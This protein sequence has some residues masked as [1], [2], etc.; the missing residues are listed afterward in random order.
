MADRLFLAATHSGLYRLRLDDHFAL[1]ACHKLLAGHHYAL[2]V[3]PSEKKIYSKNRDE[4]LNVYSASDLTK[5]A[6]V[7]FP[8]GP[9]QVHQALKLANGVLLT[10]TL[11][12]RITYQPSD[13]STAEHFVIDD[14]HD[15]RNHVNSL[16]L[17]SGGFVAMLHNLGAGPSELLDI[18]FSPS[19]GFD[20]RQRRSLE[21]TR[22]H[23]VFLD[24]KLCFYNASDAGAFVVRDMLHD[25]DVWRAEFEGH[26]KG[27]TVTTDHLVFGLSEVAVQ[28]DRGRSSS[29]LVV[30]DRSRRRV[31]QLVPILDSDS[32][33]PIG[34]INEL[35]CLSEP[36]FSEG[37]NAIARL[38]QPRT[39]RWR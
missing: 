36:D 10:D 37:S 22:C 11:H 5:L 38:V 32:G 18:D 31:Q 7:P 26:S 8:S 19:T 28:A 23:N 4:Y 20:L 39:S 30:V 29:S 1:Q 16:C 3:R 35:R 14:H 25:R 24:G 13:G 33:N 27:L 9:A 17:R 34:N 21:D 6:E 12:N 15:D 2:S